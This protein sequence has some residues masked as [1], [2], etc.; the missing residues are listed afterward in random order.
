MFANLH[1][2]HNN[3]KGVISLHERLSLTKKIFLTS[4][5]K[6]KKHLGIL[7]LL[8]SVFISKQILQNLITN[9]TLTMPTLAMGISFQDWMTDDRSR[10]QLSKYDL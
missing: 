10:P 2:L 1:E 5:E 8:N 6:L 9:I 4:Q 3:K 7:F